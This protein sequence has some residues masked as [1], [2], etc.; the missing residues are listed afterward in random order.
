[1]TTLINIGLMIYFALVAF[2]GTLGNGII[3]LAYGNRW[4]SSKSTSVIFILILSCVDLWTC[5]VVV[6][7]IAIMEYR[8]FEVPTPL[9]RFYSF[10]K[11]LIIISSLIMS[12]IALDRFLNIAVPHYRLLNPRRVKFLLIT[13]ISIGV[14]LGLLTALAFSSSPYRVVYLANYTLIPSNQS[15]IIKNDAQ[16][17]SI[18]N[19][20]KNVPSFKLTD[21]MH[22]QLSIPVTIN[23]TDINLTYVSTHDV[24]F[25]DTAIISETIRDILRHISNKFFFISI[26]IVTI[27]Y[28]ITFIL[29]LHRQN[30]R[31]RAL[32][33][34]LNVLN[35]F[36]SYPSNNHHH[37]HHQQINSHPVKQRTDSL[38]SSYSPLV[39]SRKIKQ[40]LIDSKCLSAN[41]NQ[42]FEMASFNSSNEEH[43]VLT[44]PKTD[45][46][47]SISEGQSDDLQVSTEKFSNMKQVSFQ[48]AHS[49]DPLI[50]NDKQNLSSRSNSSDI[51]LDRNNDT[52][53]KFPCPCSTTRQLLIKFHFAQPTLDINQWLCYCCMKKSKSSNDKQLTEIHPLEDEAATILPPHL[54]SNQYHQRTSIS[55]SEILKRQLHRH[56]I[57]QI[58]MASTFL[59]ITVSFVLFYLPSILNAERYIKSP[60]WI[61]Y[62]YLCTHALNPIIYCFMNVNL[63]VYII[64]MLKCQ[65]KHRRHMSVGGA[66]IFER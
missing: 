44:E 32:K 58:R 4:N 11:I 12:F 14:G 17:I 47:R 25:A 30:P 9:C 55:N 1:M 57:K 15:F 16:K 36:D 35:K 38:A 40:S 39:A 7:T 54:P 45:F 2:I 60:L 19:E 62:L 59:L 27:L 50:N 64:S 26:G 21:L 6:P 10:S 52:Y 41:D 43:D 37:H 24:C 63:R 23:I 42:Q 31:I 8:E 46:H 20:Q 18:T 5:L 3:L 13:F 29:A 65:T 61:Y 28:A 49:E 51:D 33:K 56:R 48:V 66:S 22:E 34:S 53:Y